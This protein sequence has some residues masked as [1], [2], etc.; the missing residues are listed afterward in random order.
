[1]MTTRSH[2]RLLA[3]AGG[4]LRPFL[5][6][7]VG[8]LASE[9]DGRSS[10]DWTMFRGNPALTGVA[11]G[12]LPDKPAQLWSFKTAGPVKSSAAIV[13]GRVFIG[14]DDAKLYAL[15]LAGGKKLWEF[16][17][18][19]PIE[20]SPL[21]LNGKVYFGSASTNVFALEAA[22]GKKLWS[23]GVEGEIKSSPNWVKS[24]DGK[25][26]WILVGGY[27]NRLHCLDAA[28]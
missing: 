14:S 17:A 6:S 1:M 15:N 4:A 7:F 13:E 12:T 21:V 8:T 20:S 16:T 26:F 22:T 19:G 28:T 18:D 23:H 10:S 11:S 3:A 25:A 2:R 5:S 24:P 27:D 9:Q